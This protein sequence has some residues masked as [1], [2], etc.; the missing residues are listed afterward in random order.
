MQGEA[1]FRRHWITAHLKQDCAVGSNWWRGGNEKGEIESNSSPLFFSATLASLPDFSTRGKPPF[2]LLF[3]LCRLSRSRSTCP[4][5]SIWTSPPRL[6]ISTR[7]RCISPLSICPSCCS[8]TYEKVL[9]C[10]TRPQEV[11]FPLKY[12]YLTVKTRSSH[13]WSRNSLKWH[14]KFKKKDCAEVMNFNS[15]PNSYSSSYS[16]LQAIF[17]PFSLPSAGSTLLFRRRDE[18]KWQASPDLW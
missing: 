7:S 17:S 8:A 12:N 18:K 9:A 4:N 11:S 3:A 16:Y 10:W 6:L 15:N 2:C 5:V 14:G 1:V 13:W